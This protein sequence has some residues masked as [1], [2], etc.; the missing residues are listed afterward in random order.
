[1]Y[2]R[3]IPGLALLLL[4]QLSSLAVEVNP[5]IKD[6]KAS[7]APLSLKLTKTLESITP[8]GCIQKIE[9]MDLFDSDETCSCFKP[10]YEDVKPVNIASDEEKF[11][12]TG[13]ALMTK[14]Q[15]L[16]TD[17]AQLATL[18]PSL[19]NDAEIFESCGVERPFEFSGNQCNSNDPK[20]K[21]RMKKMFGFYLKDNETIGV[22]GSNQFSVDNLV[23]KLGKEIRLYTSPYAK[24]DI[25]NENLCVHPSMNFFVQKK[26]I[27]IYLNEKNREL[28]YNSVVLD[29]DNTFNSADDVSFFNLLKMNNDGT[30]DK[31]GLNLLKSEWNTIGP[32]KN[33]GEITSSNK[34]KSYL[35]KK[36]IN[37][38]NDINKEVKEAVC[39][40]KINK[41]DLNI[42]KNNKFD[43]ILNII[44]SGKLESDDIVAGL[45]SIKKICKSETNGESINRVW[46]SLTGVNDLPSEVYSQNAKNAVKFTNEM[47]KNL[48]LCSE[49]CETDGQKDDVGFCKKKDIDKL[50]ANYQCKS[51][52]S[53]D[54]S[55]EKLKCDALSLLKEEGTIK[56]IEVALKQY[57]LKERD[58]EA[59]ASIADHIRMRNSKTGGKDLLSRF[60]DRK[61]RKAKDDNSKKKVETQ[62]SI[63]SISEESKQTNHDVTK[64]SDSLIKEEQSS[65]APIN[66]VAKQAAHTQKDINVDSAIKRF[67]STSANLSFG[68]SKNRNASTNSKKSKTINNSMSSANDKLNSLM[69]TLDELRKDNENISSIINNKDQKAY[70]AKT[71]NPESQSRSRSQRRANSPSSDTSLSGNS[72]LNTS[73]FGNVANSNSSRN[74]GTGPS[75]IQE[76]IGDIARTDLIGKSSTGVSSPED[77][78]I[79]SQTAPGVRAPASVSKRASSSAISKLFQGSLE[80][81]SIS[82]NT[83]NSKLVKVEVKD[84]VKEVNLAELLKNRDEI[85]PGEAFI[86]Y[87]LVNKRKVEV[88]LIPTFSNYKGKRFFA[89]YRPLDINKSNKILVDKL[90]AEKNLLTQN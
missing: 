12:E 47:S 72:G 59:Y 62:E 77:G 5:C 85:S 20:V 67:E 81:S 16:S 49:I 56:E 57:D 36:L 71:L 11:E 68:G 70:S 76:P 61:G 2:L 63:A 66:K 26:E 41:L 55:I 3:T 79:K 27:D 1:M 42:T 84:G 4:L 33:S 29:S 24:P 90:K 69:S 19:A 64:K 35:K 53:T 60:L 43:H 87:E 88:T 9:N 48:N 7:T 45:G 52:D 8:K 73:P 15:K 21:Q 18:M 13:N 40:D 80:S 34:L 10:Y 30:V 82:D 78:D 37:R 74:N 6:T 31:K 54:V 32:E 39:S 51:L 17:F 23:D 22:K 83:N 28:L 14:F 50:L 86:L 58:P 46:E 44:D 89:G 65:Q 75:Q 38:C 25:H